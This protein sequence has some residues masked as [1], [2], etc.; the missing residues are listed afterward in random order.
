M[1]ND[2]TMNKGFD[3]SITNL[4]YVKAYTHFVTPQLS[5]Y[6]TLSSSKPIL[7]DQ[8]TST[9][10]RMGCGFSCF[11][12]TNVQHEDIRFEAVGLTAEHRED[13]NDTRVEEEDRQERR[14]ERRDATFASAPRAEISAAQR[15]EVNQSQPIS[16]GSV[17]SLNSVIY[18]L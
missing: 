10:T 12:R 16:V 9:D 13:V 4:G 5:T 6:Q 15:R 2:V 3:H 14:R 7:I 1:V 11:S 17:S 18:F 8:H